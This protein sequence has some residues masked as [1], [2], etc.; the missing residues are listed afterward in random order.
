MK[1]VSV[2]ELKARLSECLRVV[3]RGG[4]VQVLDRGVPVARLVAVGPARGPDAG[5]RDRLIRAGILRTGTGDASA[6]LRTRA[7]RFAADLSTAVAD[8]RAD[9]A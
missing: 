8:D 4:E 2:S 6:L 5:R 9:R 1:V 3:K 7:L